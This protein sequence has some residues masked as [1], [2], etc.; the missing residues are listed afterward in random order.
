MPITHCA[1]AERGMH[2]RLMYFVSQRWVVCPSVLEL[3]Q[4]GLRQHLGA[5]VHLGFQVEKGEC[6]NYTFFDSSW[7]TDTGQP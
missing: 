4:E 5:N 7:A 1:R 2:L 3:R 6:D